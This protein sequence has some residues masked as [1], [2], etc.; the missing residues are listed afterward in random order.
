MPL[1]TF[2]DFCWALLVGLLASAIV[3]VVVELVKKRKASYHIRSRKLSS[4]VYAAQTSGDVEIK[5]SYKSHE[6][7]SS[8]LVMDM[9]LENDG[10][11]DIRF[12][13]HFS[14]GI[15]IK[16]PKFKFI[17]SETLSSDVSAS[18]E[19]TE[20]YILVRWDI[21]KVGEPILLK[22]VAE[23]KDNTE[24]KKKNEAQFF[25]EL[26]Y[27]FRSD[28]INNICPEENKKPLIFRISRSPYFAF[29]SGVVMLTLYLF[30]AL[31]VNVQYSFESGDDNE[32]VSFST[33][34]YSPVFDKCILLGKGTSVKVVKPTEMPL[35]MTFQPVQR[36]TLDFAASMAIEVMV[37][38]MAFLLICVLIMRASIKWRKE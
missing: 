22:I 17:Y 5:V 14:S 25:R 11:Q 20:D 7:N 26:Q 6:V 4:R 3:A 37:Y 38:V 27:E 9:V 1:F 12:D 34:L 8:L 30:M 13:T 32:Y 35:T 23:P 31:S 15:Y 10:K 36:S 29:L 28:C 21:L 16:N 18:C 2:Q 24:L 33:V 19:F